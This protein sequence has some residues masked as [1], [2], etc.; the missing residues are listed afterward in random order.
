MIK[1]SL[2]KV[3]PIFGINPGKYAGSEE[4]PRQYPAP[5]AIPRETSQGQGYKDE[6]TQR[7]HY[8]PPP[9]QAPR[10]NSAQPTERI[11]PEPT[12][13]TGRY[14]HNGQPQPYKPTGQT[15]D[16]RV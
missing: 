4:A 15:L 2:T 14:D 5:K 7:R 1:I 9:V 12:I 11:N 16:T 13:F 3:E 10:Y 8:N 6:S